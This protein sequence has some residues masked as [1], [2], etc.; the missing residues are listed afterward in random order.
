MWDQF[1]IPILFLER[2]DLVWFCVTKTN[3]GN[4]VC[5]VSGNVN[6]LN[7]LTLWL[8]GPCT[9]GDPGPVPSWHIQYSLHA[10]DLFFFLPPSQP[11]LPAVA[12]CHVLYG[13]RVGLFS[14]SP[15]LES[16][17]FIWAVQRMLATTPPLLYLPPRLLHRIGA[18]LWTEHATA[19]DYIFSHGRTHIL[20]RKNNGK[21]VSKLW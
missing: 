12:S 19:W 8:R 3:H 7:S 20:Q 15:S 13:E 6:E 17:K 1:N 5:I 16:Q 9:P 4:K 2:E 21:F 11:L 14:L 10:L 18:P